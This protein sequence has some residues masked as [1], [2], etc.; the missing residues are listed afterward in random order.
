MKEL[1]FDP[2]FRPTYDQLKA[3]CLEAR[4]KL[5]AQNMRIRLLESTLETER[6]ELRRLQFIAGPAGRPGW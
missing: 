4:A 1:N 6:T 5:D 2:A 3:W